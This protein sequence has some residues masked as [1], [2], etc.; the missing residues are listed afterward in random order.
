[1]PSTG[2]VPN[3]SLPNLDAARRTGPN[4]IPPNVP[5]GA[6][7]GGVNNYGNGRATRLW[8][9]NTVLTQWVAMYGTSQQRYNKTKPPGGGT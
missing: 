7:R 8:Y 6:T 3:R 4:P 2:I 5:V 1:M 9:D